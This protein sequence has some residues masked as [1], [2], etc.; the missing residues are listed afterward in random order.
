[1]GHSERW[2]EVAAGQTKKGGRESGGPSALK[3]PLKMALREKRKKEE[4]NN[5][6][7]L[8]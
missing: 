1:M 2:Y 7:K 6:S 3:L 8:S 5:N 4:R